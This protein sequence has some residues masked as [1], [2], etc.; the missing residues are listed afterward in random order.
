MSNNKL[1]DAKNIF[2]TYGE[3]LK[4]ERKRRSIKQGELAKKLDINQSELSRWE[5][6]D[7]VPLEHNQ[8][9]IKHLLNIIITPVKDGWEVI[10]AQQGVKNENTNFVKEPN[11]RYSIEQLLREERS[12]L[13]IS[14]VPDS[15]MGRALRDALDDAVSLLL[16][17]RRIDE[18]N[19]KNN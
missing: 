10:E 15:E 7:M 16:K 8:E 19:R 9:K 2:S 13:G 14:D 1:T 3:A 17:L 18:L 12:R 6:K 11:E 5:N 4:F